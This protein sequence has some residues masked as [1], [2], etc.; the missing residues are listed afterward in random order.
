MNDCSDRAELTVR[1]FAPDDAAAWR[2]F[3]SASANG[4]LFHDLDFLAYHP[5]GRFDFRHLLVERADRLEAIVPGAL[6]ADGFFSSPVGASVGGPVVKK[7]LRA[8]ATIE[9]IEALRRHARQEG[10]RGLEFTLSPPVY[11][12][13]PNQLIEF[14]LH[15]EGFQ[16][17]HRALP[18]ILTLS[19]DGPR[20]YRHL[21]SQS[22]RSYVRANLRKGVI[23]R[24]HGIEGAPAFLDLFLETYARLGAVPTHSPSEIENLLQRKPENV[25]LWLAFFEGTPIAGVLMLILNRRVCNAFYICDRSSYRDQHGVAV[26]LAIAI[27]ALADR[28]FQYLDL[29]PSASSDHVNEGVLF[30]KETLG[31]RGFCRDRWRWTAA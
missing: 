4:T 25:R 21:F 1:Y 6:R 20:R 11:A 9:L 17:I 24:E 30:L 16:L 12:E 26:L 15:R 5:P 22:R 8:I 2:S 3:L 29:G 7:D 13:V 18:L 19:V 23:A 14:A 10:W 31:G 28:G 27:D